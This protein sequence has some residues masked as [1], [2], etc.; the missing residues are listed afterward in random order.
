MEELIGKICNTESSIHKELVIEEKEITELKDIAEEFSDFFTNVCPNLA[1]KAANS[2][3]SFTSFLNQIR[4][5]TGKKLAINK[6]AKVGF[7]L[8]EN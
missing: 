4:S 5:I 2:S 3:N 8:I 7:L 6:L 1:K